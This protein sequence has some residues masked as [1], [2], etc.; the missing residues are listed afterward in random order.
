MALTE[1]PRGEK[2]PS[3]HREDPR[4]SSE[5]E[6]RQNKDQKEGSSKYWRICAATP[7]TA[8]VDILVPDMAATSQDASAV[9]EERDDNA[10]YPGATTSGLILP[11]KSKHFQHKHHPLLDRQVCR[12]AKSL[13]PV[14]KSRPNR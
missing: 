9:P 11:C 6:E 10:S 7:A 13:S 12:I 2:A 1:A 8:G 5:G 4:T 14:V 3:V